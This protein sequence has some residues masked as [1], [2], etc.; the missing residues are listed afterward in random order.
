M[1]TQLGGGLLHVRR[2]DGAA[3]ILAPALAEAGAWAMM[4]AAPADMRLDGELE[5]WLDRWGVAAGLRL[6]RLRQ[7]HGNRV[8]AAGDVALDGTEADGVWTVSG[9][10]VLSVTCADCAP[11]WIAAPTPQALALV[12]AGWRGIA[13][14]ILDSALTALRACGAAA[15]S[16]VVAVGPHLRPCCFEVGPEVARQ[17]DSYPGSVQSPTALRAQR[18]RRDS[19]ALDL[20]IPIVSQ[21]TA[22]GVA[23]DHIYVA[24]ACTRCT[25]EL[26]HSYRRNGPGG[27]LMAAVGFLKA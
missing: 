7:V 6:R 22:L 11:V 13:A 3:A 23:T 4:S 27:P 18:Q 26:L 25:P 2:A 8:A 1:T 9:E 24:T 12:H 15:E 17:F 19:S 21:L 10:D 5:C 20:A 14:G 16:L